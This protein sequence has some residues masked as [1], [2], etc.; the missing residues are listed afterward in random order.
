MASSTKLLLKLEGYGIEGNLLQWFRNFLTNR[1]QRVVVRGTTSSWSSVRSGVPQGTIVGPILFLIYM[2]NILSNISLTIRLFANSVSD[3][4]ALQTDFDHLANWATL[5]QLRFNPGKCETMFITHNRDKSSPTC[6][7]GVAIKPVK[8]VKDLGVLI[9]C[10]LT[11][12]A[13]VDATVSKANKILGIVY[14]T[15]AP[16]N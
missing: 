10:D 9:S 6:T 7:V 5:C 1:Q 11:W 15:L 14:R 3:T 12:G 8:C 16:T 13:Q 2:N 4:R